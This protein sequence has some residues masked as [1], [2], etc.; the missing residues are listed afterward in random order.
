MFRERLLEYLELCVTHSALLIIS[1]LTVERRW[2]WN[3]TMFHTSPMLY[4]ISP[5]IYTALL[6]H[7]ICAFGPPCTHMH[8]HKHTQT[9]I[10]LNVAE[11]SGCSNNVPCTQ[12]SSP[13]LILKSKSALVLLPLLWICSISFRMNHGAEIVNIILIL[14]FLPC[15]LCHSAW[16]WFQM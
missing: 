6:L 2:Q 14:T 8:T 5:L 16:L 7:I 10:F 11:L 1:A 15:R 12:K 13:S 4:L 9:V 3:N